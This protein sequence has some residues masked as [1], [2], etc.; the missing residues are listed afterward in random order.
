MVRLLDRGPRVTATK[1]GNTG[2]VKLTPPKSSSG[3]RLMHWDCNFISVGNCSK[4]GAN[5]VLDLGFADLNYI[6][7]GGIFCTVLHL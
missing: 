5:T 3:G 1:Q 4:L 2:S 7:L 6:N